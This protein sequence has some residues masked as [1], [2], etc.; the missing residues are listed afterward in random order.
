MNLFGGVLCMLVH[1]MV[2]LGKDN[3]RLPICNTTNYWETTKAN[4]ILNKNANL[5]FLSSSRH[6]PTYMYSINFL[7][8]TVRCTLKLPILIVSKLSMPSTQS[9]SNDL[10]FK[11]K[12]VAVHTSIMHHRFRKKLTPTVEFSDKKILSL[13]SKKMCYK[14]CATL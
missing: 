1:I 5:V 4:W 12:I 9:H 13:I 6:Y 11:L 14:I 8:Y 3:R 10:N 7:S 2:N